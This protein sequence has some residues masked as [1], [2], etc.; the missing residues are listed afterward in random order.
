[1][2]WDRE[3]WGSDGEF[4]IDGNLKSVEYADRLPAIKTSTLIIAQA[5]SDGP[6]KTPDRGIP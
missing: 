4:V 1:M 6:S 2:A 3:M 5:R